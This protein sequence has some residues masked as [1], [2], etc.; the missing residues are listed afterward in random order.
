M[1]PESHVLVYC[2]MLCQVTQN[3]NNSDCRGFKSSWRFSYRLLFHNWPFS[4][5]TSGINCARARH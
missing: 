3:R 1:P 5:L 2:E 4:K